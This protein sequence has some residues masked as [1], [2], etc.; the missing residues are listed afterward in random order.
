MEG[1]NSVKMAGY[2]MYPKISVLPSGY[3]KFTGRISIPVSYKKGEEM[4]DTRIFHNICA[5][6]PVAEGL[7]ELI[8]DTPIQIHGSVS[9]RT[10]DGK[11][12]HCGNADKRY[13]TEIQ[14][15][16][17]VVLTEE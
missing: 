2:L 4:V 1:L 7:G 16:N 14:V 9:T 8:A 5:F 15:S 10:Y 13:W 12:K 11:C 3:Q 6:G 17:F